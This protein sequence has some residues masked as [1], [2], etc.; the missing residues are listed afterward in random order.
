MGRAVL[1]ANTAPRLRRFAGGNV[2]TGDRGGV[3]LMGAI[4]RVSG[5]P[6]I[7]SL[8]YI[9]DDGNESPVIEGWMV[10][11]FIPMEKR[12]DVD[13]ND[14]N[15]REVTQIIDAAITAVGG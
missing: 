15:R 10:D 2:G 8:S 14:T 12:E 5:P 6:Q 1:D 7:I 9:D 3:I 4:C 11:V 13:R